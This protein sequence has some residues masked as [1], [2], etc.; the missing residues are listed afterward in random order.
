MSYILDSTTIRSPNEFDE[1]NDTQFA[2]VR[3]LDGTINRDYFGS[4]KRKWVLSY[5]NTN[6]ND[7]DIINTIYQSYLSDAMAVTFQVTET[8]YTVSE[9][10]VHIDLVQRSFG[11]K[12]TDYL[13]DFDLILTEA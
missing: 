2:Q 1:T 3:T 10:E 6:K 9:T 4:N 5:Q 13:S 11:V 8:S 7:Y 12:G